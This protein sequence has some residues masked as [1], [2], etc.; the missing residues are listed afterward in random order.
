MSNSATKIY[1]GTGVASLIIPNTGGLTD[2]DFTVF[3]IEFYNKSGNTRYLMCFDG[4]AVPSNGAAPILPPLEVATT[5]VGSRTYDPGIRLIGTGLVFAI[6]STKDTLT[7]AADTS[8][9]FVTVEDFQAYEEGGVSTAGDYTTGV[10]SLQVW[11][12]SAGPKR[13]YKVEV[14]EAGG[15]DTFIQLFAKD[16]PSDGDT[17]LKLLGKVLANSTRVFEF[18]SGGYSPFDQTTAFALRDG[19]TIVG[20]STAATKTVVAA[21]PLKIKA[22]YKT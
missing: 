18:G 2:N 14:K 15:A 22:T 6:S 3:H 12:D 1:S 8:N 4:S 10:A 11:A 20:S 13:L 17:P 19:C 9:I 16:S 5:V 7:A 21:T